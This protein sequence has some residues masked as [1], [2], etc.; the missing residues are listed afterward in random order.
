VQASWRLLYR[1][2]LVESRVRRGCTL[3]GRQAVRMDVVLLSVTVS[4]E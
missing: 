1:T 3:Y 2:S 4:P